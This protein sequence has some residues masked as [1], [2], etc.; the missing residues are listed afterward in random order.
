M[1]KIL[2]KKFTLVLLVLSLVSG[3]IVVYYYHNPLP[4]GS[5]LLARRDLV[6]LH[7][8]ANSDSPADQQIKLK[9]R[10]AVLNYLNSYLESAADSEEA[11]RIVAAHAGELATV[12]NQTLAANNFNYPAAVQLGTFDFPL[13]SYGNLVL[14]AGRYEAV[15]IL[16]GNGEG[17][18]W[19]C[20]IFPPLCFVD[21]T[22]AA[23]VSL[24][25]PDTAGPEADN[26]PTQVHFKF[27]IAELFAK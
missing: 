12:A 18:N 16:L 14:P 17:K 2:I 11:K 13:K 8:I 19:W 21:A 26:D 27:K 23:P 1:K 15:R 24:S 5:E 4:A 9:V 20:V 25:P 6:R 7:I 22:N 3:W 10:D